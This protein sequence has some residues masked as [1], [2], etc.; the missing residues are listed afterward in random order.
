MA[1]LEKQKQTRL[2][3]IAQMSSNAAK[4]LPSTSKVVA[5]PSNVKKTVSSVENAVLQVTIPNSTN[6]IPIPKTK[7]NIKHDLIV[8]I[9]KDKRNVQDLSGT[10]K[11]SSKPIVPPV[12]INNVI[13]KHL[14]IPNAALVPCPQPE[15][16]VRRESPTPQRSAEEIMQMKFEEVMEYL[17]R[18]L[19]TM[20]T[21]QRAQ[22]LSNS[23][24]RYHN[25][26][27]VCFF[28]IL[29]INFNYFKRK[30]L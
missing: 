4:N 7:K 11:S 9:N 27:L 23:E 10:V 15:Q 13:E 18:N 5:P 26:W 1:L 12:A 24:K 19:D 3:T 29:W 22:L 21:T 30:C 20:N 16:P 28:E 2:K 6:S 8:T 14:P 17:D 25:H